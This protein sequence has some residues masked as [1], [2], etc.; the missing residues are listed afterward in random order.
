MN[1]RFG[2][3][4]WSLLV[5]EDWDAQHDEECAT[6]IGEIG[7]LQVSAAFK[8]TEVLDSDL[9]DF[10]SDHI[11]AG[12]APRPMQAGDF[13]GF[14]IAFG[15]DECFWRHWYLR[16]DKQRVGSAVRTIWGVLLQ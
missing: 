8:E 15:D 6:L 16:N 1:T 7:A 12:A 11:D 14:E 10:A 3:E 2:R 9:R 5:P 13:V 4:T